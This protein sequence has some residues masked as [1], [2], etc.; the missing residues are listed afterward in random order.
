METLLYFVVFTKPWLGA[1]SLSEFPFRDFKRAMEV[2]TQLP[3]ALTGYVDAAFVLFSVIYL[4][5]HRESARLLPYRRLWFVF[6]ALL[7]L[8]SLFVARFPLIALRR[9]VKVG[10]FF[11]MYAV[12]FI[13]AR[14]S[15]SGTVAYLRWVLRSAWVPVLYGLGN[16]IIHAN[17]SWTAFSNRDY[18]EYS[19]FLHANPF[20]YF[21][22][23]ALV[24]VAILWRY[25]T[26]SLRQQGKM[27]LVLPAVLLAAA[28]LAT[29]TRAAILGCLTAYLLIIRTSWKLKATTACV[30]LVVLL[31]VPTFI[32]PVQAIGQVTLSN[33]GSVSEAMV[34]VAHQFGTEDLEHT[35]ELAGR[36]LIWSTMTT[37]LEGHYA[38]GHGL[39][40]SAWFYEEERGEFYYAHNDY[41]T[42]LFETG[43][44]GLVLYWSIL[45]GVAWLLI[46]QRGRFAFGSLPGLLV[47]AGLFLI[48]FLGFVSFTDNLFV[49]N[50][51]TPLIWGL[52]GSATGTILPKRA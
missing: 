51:N 6:L 27:N 52:L 10:V 32:N 19:T 1:L 42:L 45:I 26:G 33:G 43:V 46:Q 25:R 22:V 5:R 9:L 37:A 35:G 39:G 12:A 3:T 40:S 23:I 16:F 49:D 11:S 29:G 44:C 30:A 28:I 17:L 13:R 41:I 34:E 18:R 38:F 47:T 15:Q 36:L 14:E 31:Q 8:T 20:A 24:V 21:C 4:Y 7:L 2:Q 48:V 50:Y